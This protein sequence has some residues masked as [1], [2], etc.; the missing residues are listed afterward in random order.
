MNDEQVE[1]LDPE[2]I[3][4]LK[5]LADEFSDM[6]LLHAPE[7]DTDWDSIAWNA[8]IPVMY[9]YMRRQA[10]AAAPDD[11]AVERAAKAIHQYRHDIGEDN[12]A[13]KAIVQTE[14]IPPVGQCHHGTEWYRDM[15]R[16]ALTAAARAK[17]EVDATD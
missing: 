7:I 8:C 1:R 6:M 16:A 10:A 5:S 17:G 11:D 15:A 4:G 14:S 12:R 2:V 3:E 9:G 13:W